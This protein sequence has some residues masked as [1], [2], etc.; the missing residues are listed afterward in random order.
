MRLS[1]PTLE[2]LLPT[3]SCSPSSV[4]LC[5]HCAVSCCC[6]DMVV[7]VMEEYFIRDASKKKFGFNHL[8]KNIHYEEFKAMESGAYT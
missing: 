4:F 6:G 3:L 8:K 2:T 7:A 1:L 5:K